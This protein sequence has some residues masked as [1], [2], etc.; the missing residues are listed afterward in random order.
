MVISILLVR[1]DIAYVAE[2]TALEIVYYIFAGQGV[3]VGK[4]TVQVTTIR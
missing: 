1:T 3:A 4:S 2:F